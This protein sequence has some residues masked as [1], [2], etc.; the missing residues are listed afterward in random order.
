[1]TPTPCRV[2]SL[3]AI[4]SSSV[5]CLIA[6]PTFLYVLWDPDR[7]QFTHRSK[8]MTRRFLSNNL[9]LTKR[10]RGGGSIRCGAIFIPGSL[11]DGHPH[12]AFEL[13][14]EAALARGGAASVA[15]ACRRVR[16][17]EAEYRE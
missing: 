7:S 9:P 6:R 16:P 3:V 12:W 15:Q 4:V 10:L 8:F 2:S 1:M 13:R 17:A 14:H 5:D 11:G